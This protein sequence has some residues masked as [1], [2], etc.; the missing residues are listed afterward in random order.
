MSALHCNPFQNPDVK[1]TMST[2]P[3]QTPSL[4]PGVSVGEA[5]GICLALVLPEVHRTLL[6]GRGWTADRYEAWLADT[7]IRQL[8]HREN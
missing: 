8:L 3:P 2:R 1:P 4:A 6:L 5:V 7:L